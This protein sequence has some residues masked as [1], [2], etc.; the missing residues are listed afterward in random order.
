MLQLTLCGTLC[1]DFNFSF[2]R[3][4]P[5]KTIQSE[6]Q[7]IIHDISRLL[8]FN[9][10]YIQS[11]L[12]NKIIQFTNSEYGLIVKPSESNFRIK[13]ACSTF[14][15]SDVN[16][17]FFEDTDLYEDMF[18]LK[19][20]FLDNRQNLRYPSMKR[21]LSIPIVSP[22]NHKLIAILILCNKIEPYTKK[23][24]FNLQLILTHFNYLFLND[25]FHP[26]SSSP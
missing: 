24:I 13:Y 20:P 11:H 9:Q 21:I 1:S 22:E 26:S 5:K 12:L 18:L 16:K 4:R 19:R 8:S 15:I 6:I 10:S 14:D 23:D 25:C 7:S 3:F 17:R 2:K